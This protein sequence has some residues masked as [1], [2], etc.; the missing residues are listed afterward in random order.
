MPPFALDDRRPQGVPRPE[1]LE[2]IGRADRLGEAVVPGVRRKPERV[3]TVLVAHARAN[4]PNCSAMGRSSLAYEAKIRPEAA[5]RRPLGRGVGRRDVAGVHLEAQGDL[6]QQD[7]AE[8]DRESSPGGLAVE[9]GRGPEPEFLA[10]DQF[11]PAELA[12]GRV[13]LDALHEGG[14]GD[15]FV[16]RDGRLAVLGR[17]DWYEPATACPRTCSAWRATSS[18]GSGAPAGGGRLADRWVKT[19]IGDQR[20][21]ATTRGR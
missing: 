20:S 8:V 9:G 17:R 3:R 19:S 11:G 16:A 5:R 12:A 18:I 7:A 21:G 4:R 15:Q 13:E 14:E 10:V 2:D 6:G 1:E